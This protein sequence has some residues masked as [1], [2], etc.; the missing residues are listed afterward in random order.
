MSTFSYANSNQYIFSF[1][2]PPGS[3]KGTLAQK[4]VHNDDYHMLSTGN[5]CREHVAQGSKFGKMI[6]TFLKNGLLIPDDVITDMVIDWLN[7]ELKSGKPIIL[8]GFPRTKGQ[9]LHFVEFLE[10]TL[11]ISKFRVF[12]IELPEDEIISRLSRRLV[13]GNTHCQTP[14]TAASNIMSCAV[15]GS[16]LVRRS[17]DQESVVRE[18]LKQYSNYKQLLLDYYVMSNVKVEPLLIDRLDPEQVYS[19]FKTLLSSV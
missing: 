15:C 9:A 7:K 11:L 2:G 16:G 18:R 14:F 1:F 13:C 8:D 12:L 10:K 4:L 19:K 17:D 3:G 5:L 6:D